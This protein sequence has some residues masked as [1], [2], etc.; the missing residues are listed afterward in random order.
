MEFSFLFFIFFLLL[1]TKVWNLGSTPTCTGSVR[2]W[3]FECWCSSV[4]YWEWVRDKLKFSPTPRTFPGSC[5]GAGVFYSKTCVRSTLYFELVH[6]LDT[7]QEH[8]L[9]DSV[10]TSNIRDLDHMGCDQFFALFITCLIPSNLC[11]FVLRISS[12]NSLILCAPIDW[13]IIPDDG[14]NL[15]VMLGNVELK[16]FSLFSSS[17]TLASR[18]GSI[19]L[20][21]WIWHFN[22]RF[23]CIAIHSGTWTTFEF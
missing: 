2:T 18:S 13:D 4:V 20:G 17:N 16:E 19:Q 6:L 21:V 23:K 12:S 1:S 22:F 5:L 7:L 11:L 8:L 9:M 14:R 15:R 10:Q 3:M